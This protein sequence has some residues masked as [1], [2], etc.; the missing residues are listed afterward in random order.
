MYVDQLEELYYKLLSDDPVD[1][2]IHLFNSYIPDLL[3][4]APDLD[5]NQ[6]IQAS[7]K[8]RVAALELVWAS[9]GLLGIQ[10][11]A[12]KVE[13]PR[14]LGNSVGICSFGNQIEEQVLSWLDSENNSLV[15]T[16]MG[17]VGARYTEMNEWEISA[18]TKYGS[19]WSDKAWSAFCLSLP[20]TRFLLKLLETLSQ[21]TQ[22]AFWESLSNYYLTEQEAMCVNPVLERLL[23][24]N[25]PFAA[26]RAAWFYLQNPA[27]KKPLNRDLLGRAL[28]LALIKA[29]DLSTAGPTVGHEMSEILK[30]LQSVSDF[31]ENRLARIEWMY[32]PLMGSWG[33]QPI[34]LIDTVTKDPEF[35]VEIICL[36]HSGKPPI[37]G[38]FPNLSPEL[39]KQLS[40]SS[41]HLLKLLEKLP[42]QS[43]SGEIDSQQLQEWIEAAR[44][45]CKQKNRREVG[46][47]YIGALLSRSPT[48]KDGIW[49]HEAIRSI[50]ESADSKELG[51]GI[52]DG[53]WDQSGA[54]IRALGEGGKQER[55]IAED[56]QRD[57]E[58]IRYA[59]PRTAAILLRIAETY[60]R[61][62]IFWDNQDGIVSN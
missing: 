47:A 9:Q 49:P 60:Q 22:T 32:L 50:I 3:E 25:R 51:E 59:W 40:L 14:I 55:K 20:L 6:K 35:F 39:R 61:F 7:E 48:G 38:E 44:A 26:I 8:E 41:W 10:K 11:L 52:E 4:A 53:R 30:E 36:L 37:E 18:R 1:K 2:S 62:A 28:E 29:S 27:L 15:Q 58:K 16:A 54:V 24:R 46:D 19:N 56:Y 57:A 45:G 31:D 43:S 33:I 23:S 12:L 34:K 5:Y 21:N 13:M 42:G 17:Y